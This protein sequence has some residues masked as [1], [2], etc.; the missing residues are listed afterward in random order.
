MVLILLAG[1][2]TFGGPYLSYLLIHLETNYILSM[3]SGFATFII[4][5]TLIWYVVTRKIIS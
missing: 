4:G 2:F 3:I 1:I 5:L